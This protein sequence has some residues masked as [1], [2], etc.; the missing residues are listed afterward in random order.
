M[1]SEPETLTPEE[2]A[3][4]LARCGPAELGEIGA[5][6]AQRNRRGAV[7][8]AISIAQQP[9]ALKAAEDL[10]GVIHQGTEALFNLLRRSS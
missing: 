3:E 4:E 8:L 2:L 6:L 5:M 7:V 1:G 9:S 10:G